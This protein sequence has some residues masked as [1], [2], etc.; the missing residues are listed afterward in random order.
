MLKNTRWAYG[1]VVFTGHESKLMRNATSAPIK[2]TNVEKMT[3]KQIVLLFIILLILSISSAF[4]SLDFKLNKSSTVPYVFPDGVT[5]SDAWYTFGTNLLTFIILYNNLIP[6]SLIVTMEVVKMMQSYLINSDLDI[7]YER[8]DTPAQVRTSSL[9]EELGQIEYIFSDKTGT[10]TCNEMEFKECS[11]NGRCY[12]ETLQDGRREADNPEDRQADFDTLRN[13]AKEISLDARKSLQSKMVNEFFTLLAVCHTVIPE[14]VGDAEN[15]ADEVPKP[16]S[17]VYQA[18]SPDEGALVKG[19]QQMGFY[20]HTRRPKSVIISVNGKNQEYEVLN[21]CEFN[22]TRKRMSSIVRCPDGKIKLYIKGADTVILERLK[23]DPTLPSDHPDSLKAFNPIVPTTLQH[24]EDYATEGLRTLCIAMREIDESEYKQWCTIYE[25]AANTVN[26]RG[27]ELDAAA[28]LIEKDLLL[29]GATAIEDKLQS[30]VPDT[31]HTLAEAGIKIW[32]LTGDRQETAINIGY[33]CKLL[34][35]DMSLMIV[36][37]E[38]KEAT[39]AYLEKKLRVIKTSAIKLGYQLPNNRFN[40]NKIKL[41]TMQRLFTRRGFRQSLVDWGIVR[42]SLADEKTRLLTGHT[43]GAIQ[44]G[45]NLQLQ[46]ASTGDDELDAARLDSLALV[47][48]GKSLKWALEPELEK[49]F[50]ELAT[51]CKAVICCRVSPLQKALVTKLVKVQMGALTLAIGDGANDV[52]MIQAAHVGIGI[53]GN[54]G[55]QA[56]RSADIAI[57]QFRFLR[58]LLLVHGSWSY[59]RL[60]RLILYSFYK[61]ICLYMTQF[62]FAFSNGFSGQTVYE[63]WII[64]SYN[65]FFTV[66]PPLA[67]G[68]FDQFISARMLDRYPTLYKLGQEKEFF[69]VRNFWGWAINAIYHS[70]LLYYLVF[71][72]LT[73]GNM[74]SGMPESVDGKPS[75]LWFAGTFLYSAVLMTVLMKAAL[76][77]DYWTKYTWLSIPGSFV[78]WIASLPLYPLTIS[79][80]LIGV[81]APLYGDPVF[82]IALIVVPSICLIRDYTWKYFKRQSITRCYHVVQEIQKFQIPDYRPHAERFK[83]AIHKV[84]MMQRMRRNRGFA[85]SQ[86]DSGQAELIRHYD[87]TVKKPSG[88]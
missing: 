85:F 4:G 79:P 46:I 2:Q 49:L 39:K 28:E 75:G 48:D 13:Q 11:I 5:V 8:N 71:N 35:E 50:L 21:I 81:P 68:I 55:L 41:T 15:H 19:A 76:T 3:N 70:A 26:N 64:S 84:R 62:W 77:V 54:E 59:Q 10:L 23:R 51:L 74:I 24:L 36:N 9:V 7:Y 88:L 86:G 56:A 43:E 12:A 33:S 44:K 63:S 42:E 87:T 29:I 47:I 82:W 67:I 30:G 57:A 52:S 25:K 14:R 17:I 27:A 37:E 53:S 31:I 6:I 69:N 22:S 61:N 60:S 65:V 16:A 38:S 18:S 1:I 20:F 73:E 32:V 83:K 58:K 34:T 80:E 40:P 45:S 78:L 66:F 72:L